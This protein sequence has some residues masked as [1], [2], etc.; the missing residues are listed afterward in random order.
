MKE[1]MNLPIFIN[2]LA[3]QASTIQMM[4][5]AV[6]EAQARWKPDS[7]TWSIL[8]V[9]HHLYDEEQFDFRVRLDIILHHPQK[10]WP[11]IDPQGWVIAR[12]YNQQDF[13]LTLRRF[14]TEREASIA[15]LR[16]LENPDWQ[17]TYAAPWGAISA[18]DM[19][20]AWV[21]HDLLH[22]RQLVELQ[23]AYTTRNLAPFSVLYAGEW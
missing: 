20:A 7:E 11:A 17:T 6:D 15:W 10:T 3:R 16:T 2:Q 1:M 8:E 19:F 21:A 23:W 22:T 5:S 9:I 18:G 4:A 12:Q 14:L 13:Q